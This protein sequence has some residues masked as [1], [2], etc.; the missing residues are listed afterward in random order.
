MFYKI[1][2]IDMSDATLEGKENKVLKLD[3][4]EVKDVDLQKLDQGQISLDKEDKIN[5]DNE[6]N[7]EP[8]K[9]ELEIKRDT[10]LSQEK[11]SFPHGFSVP[12]QMESEYDSSREL[13]EFKYDPE[14]EKGFEE[15]IESF[16]AAYIVL[17]DAATLVNKHKKLLTRRFS[18]LVEKVAISSDYNEDYDAAKLEFLAFL[19]PSDSNSSEGSL[20][21]LSDEESE[22]KCKTLIEELD[23]AFKEKE[24]AIKRENAPFKAIYKFSSEFKEAIE[25]VTQKLTGD[26]KATQENISKRISN[27]TYGMIGFGVIF[28]LI[29]LWLVIVNNQ[30]S[31]LNKDMESVENSNI[32]FE[33]EITEAKNNAISE[34]KKVGTAEATKF[35]TD[36]VTPNTNAF[37]KLGVDKTT[38][39]NEA[40]TK[41]VSVANGELTALV[42]EAKEFSVVA[43]SSASEA[44]QSAIDATASAGSSELAAKSVAGIVDEALLNSL[45][46]YKKLIDE[47]GNIIP[48]IELVLKAGNVAETA[49]KKATFSQVRLNQT[50]D[51]MSA[52]LTQVCSKGDS[53]KA[54]VLRALT[55]EIGDACKLTTREIDTS[56]L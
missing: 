7:L 46:D 6:V 22:E 32:N 35:V 3:L 27:L 41:T 18:Q 34:M 33:S 38:A 12:E 29:I 13:L 39:L 9:S 23:R 16:T 45:G 37:N 40:V 21:K 1:L 11:P 36:V 14:D 43:G 17:D 10:A 5:S 2:E 49:L 31:K 4:P 42:T 24:T 19:F 26:L 28:G 53:T 20:E 52:I 15:K 47:D 50:D 48:V 54:K 56:T 30:I 51:I 25:G 8:E 55:F 44:K